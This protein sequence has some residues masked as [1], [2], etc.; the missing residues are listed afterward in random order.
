MIPEPAR[1]RLKRATREAEPS[2]ATFTTDGATVFGHGV[3]RTRE[4]CRRELDVYRKDFRG[5]WLNPVA[6]TLADEL[7][8][9]MI[10]AGYLQ[11]QHT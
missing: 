1:L 6:Q 5:D 7:E 8:A 3:A 9:A 4:E 10:A 11:E 2:A